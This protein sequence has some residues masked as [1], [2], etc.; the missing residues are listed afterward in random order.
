MS[1][2]FYNELNILKSDLDEIIRLSTVIKNY[3]RS[4]KYTIKLNSAITTF[5]INIAKYYN[6]DG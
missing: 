5:I 4:D 6:I 3:V 1:L 2:N